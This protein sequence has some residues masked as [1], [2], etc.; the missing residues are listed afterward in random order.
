LIVG[1][2]SN[3]SKMCLVVCMM[4]IILKNVTVTIKNVLASKIFVT[5]Y[6]Q[7]LHRKK[8]KMLFHK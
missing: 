6:I 7:K 8:L 1:D 3:A 5:A 2:E 4:N